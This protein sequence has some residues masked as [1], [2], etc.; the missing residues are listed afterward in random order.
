[1]NIGFEAKRFF[2][3]YTGLGNYCRFVID[4]LSKY[5]TQNNYFLYTP[6]EVQHPEVKFIVARPNVK[7]VTPS[8]LYTFSRTTSLWR[9]W[10]ISKEPSIKHIE[11]F[12]G[13]S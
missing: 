11:I 13:L 5:V 8:A 4:A 10:C 3:N 2:T 6:R 7:V 1:M 9:T 12:H